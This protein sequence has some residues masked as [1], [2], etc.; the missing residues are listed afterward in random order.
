MKRC[1][2]ACHEF[3]GVYDTEPCKVCG[4]FNS[5]GRLPGTARDGWE[6]NPEPTTEERVA[7]VALKSGQRIANLEADLEAA[8][9]RIAKL[10][11][12]LRPFAEAW[13]AGAF[14]GTTGL[15]LA[16]WGAN[17]HRM[18]NEEGKDG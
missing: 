5:K 4:H 11:A 15:K 6:P 16:Y 17:A 9:E 18:L 1:F 14:L 13:F 7:R 3:P 10:E 2:C 12:A 8:R